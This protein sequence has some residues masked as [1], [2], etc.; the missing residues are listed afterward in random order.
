MII[1]N[2]EY[3]GKEVKAY[4]SQKQKYCSSECCYN[5]KKAKHMKQCKYCK[6]IFHYRDASQQFCSKECV[7]EYQ[8]TLIGSLSP[9]YNHVDVKCEICGKIF[10]VKKSK[11]NK[12]RFCSKECKLI[13]YKEY[14]R[15]SEKSKLQAEK[16]VKWMNDGTIKKSMTKP[17]VI[18]NNLLDELCIAHINEYNIKYYSVDIYLNEIN[19][20]IEIMGDY[21][22]SNPTTKYV[23]AKN[24]QQQNRINKDKAKHSYIK[25][26]YDIEVLYLWEH[27]IINRI[28]V[29]KQLIINYIKYNGILDNY[30]SFNYYLDDNAL[31]IKDNIIYPKFAS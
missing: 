4:K 31:R 3:C 14:K 2:C 15:T 1:F 26:Q 13:W 21:W 5:A 24:K 23:N 27:D 8:K 6:K 22:H 10:S 19:L 17:H 11:E 7:W 18:I 29:C 25:N 28:D 12:Q 30:N 20:M 16:I 9:K